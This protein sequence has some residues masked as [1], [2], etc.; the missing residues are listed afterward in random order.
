[1]QPQR[2]APSPKRLSA[3]A[4]RAGTGR[5]TRPRGGARDYN[6]PVSRA[7]DKE[8]VG[9]E[10]TSGALIAALVRDGL[11][12]TMCRRELAPGII[13]RGELRRPKDLTALVRALWREERLPTKQVR[14]AIPNQLA[15]C[16][17]MRLPDPGSR[18]DLLGAI[19]LNG[20]EVFDAI[21]LS[22]SVLGVQELDRDGAQ[23][24]VS[25]TA[26]EKPELGAFTKALQRAGLQVVSAETAASAQVRALA[27]PLDPLEISL[28]LSIGSDATTVALAERGGVSFLRS[29][30]VGV[31]SLVGVLVAGGR[32]PAEAENLLMRIG[33]QAE[34][35]GGIDPALVSE[36]QN[37]ILDP[38]DQLVQQ[39]GD[40]IDFARASRQAPI[41]RM[42]VTG[43]GAAI[44]DL[45]P[46]IAQYTASAPPLLPAQG[47]DT[48]DGVPEFG[49]YAGALALSAGGGADLLD[50]P[51]QGRRRTEED[52]GAVREDTHVSRNG[53]PRPMRQMQRRARGKERSI[54]RPYLAALVIV[55]LGVTGMVLGSRQLEDRAQERQ[56]ELASLGRTAPSQAARFSDAA[57][58]D[59]AEARRDLATPLRAIDEVLANTIGARLVRLDF[60]DGALTVDLAGPQ[61]AGQAVQDR[62]AGAGLEVERGSASAGITH[63]VIR[64]QEGS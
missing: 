27:A 24:T 15:L 5:G 12:V 55:S 56:L 45:G 30:P 14:I 54:P 17:M 44:P 48:F 38:F 57:L 63:L 31:Q 13:E 6:G 25:V 16:R 20:R 10:I 4:G 11:P 53:K 40:T 62:L 28:I 43:E 9:L 37:L 22:D 49:T 52:D 34:L 29:V 3:R 32:S 1:M 21:D 8:I 42:V 58:R 47:I 39:I 51:K 26:V 60:A 19:R 7:A 36:V 33:F 23:L 59:L 35:P 46:S 64:P 50:A 41:G 2:T 61:S 18:A